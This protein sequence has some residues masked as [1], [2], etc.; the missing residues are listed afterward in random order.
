MDSATEV[1]DALIVEFRNFVARHWA[2]HQDIRHWQSALRETGWH[3]AD[4]PVE[5]GGTGWNLATQ[6]H[7]AKTCADALAPL[8]GDEMARLAPLL[9]ALGTDKQQRHLAGIKRG[10]PWQFVFAATERF[11]EISHDGIARLADGKLWGRVP[12]AGNDVNCCL[13]VD[14]QLVL[15]EASSLRRLR[16]EK[17]SE[18]G[19]EDIP[20][21]GRGIHKEKDQ[22][23]SGVLLS[24]YD[25]SNDQVGSGVLLSG[26]D[27]SNDQV[28]GGV[29]LSEYDLSNDQDGGEVLLTGYA[30]ADEETLGSPDASRHLALHQSPLC[31]LMTQLHAN[32]L[33]AQGLASDFPDDN[34]QTTGRG[35]QL[36]HDLADLN[37]ATRSLEAMFLRGLAPEMLN[38]K[39]AELQTSTMQLLG[40]LLGY[41]RL[42]EAAAGDTGNEPELPMAAERG[43]LASMQGWAGINTMV[44]RDQLAEVCRV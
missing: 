37:I 36:E 12:I 8:P 24:G 25:L 3:C 41:Y 28:G 43:L 21:D 33:L 39:Y 16:K 23:G 26:Y 18:Q 32:Q 44:L 6:W 15:L 19:P 14:D 11:N 31:N 17:G 20:G 22:G 29:L 13:L 10:Q 38:L 4:W 30:L 40:S 35:K 2:E 27:L 5:H 34:H 9:L 42:L 1:D 7:W